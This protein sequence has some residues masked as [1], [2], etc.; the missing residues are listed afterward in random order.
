MTD[1][2]R[3][4]S[5]LDPNARAAARSALD[6]LNQALLYIDDARERCVAS[7]DTDGLMLGLENIS[8]FAAQLKVVTDAVR[9]DLATVLPKGWHS[10]VDGD[11]WVGVGGGYT[12]HWN[13]DRL[14]SAVVREGYEAAMRMTAG[15]IDVAVIVEQVR[16]AVAACAPL[17][18]ST[19]WRVT[20]LRARS[21]DPAHFRERTERTT[22]TWAAEP[23][24]PIRARLARKKGSQP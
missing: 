3:I 9:A 8:K 18:A 7:G 15:E 10:V 6:L 21:I 5:A 16:A 12:D 20:G 23:P 13:S 4:P 19:S 2:E 24:A 11:G 14:L 1:I 17:T 22:T